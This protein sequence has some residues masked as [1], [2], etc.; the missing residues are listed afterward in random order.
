MFVANHGCGWGVVSGRVLFKGVGQGRLSALRHTLVLVRRST[1]CM[2]QQHHSVQFVIK[3]CFG[4]V[5]GFS[6]RVCSM[7]EAL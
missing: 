1:S 7:S 2:F 4:G 3:G 5:F 6:A